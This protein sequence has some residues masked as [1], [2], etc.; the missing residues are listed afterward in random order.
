MKCPN[1]ANWGCFSGNFSDNGYDFGSSLFENAINKGC[2]M[3]D[4]GGPRELECS[5]FLNGSGSCKKQCDTDLCNDYGMD[6]RV[7]CQV[8]KESLD[9]TGRPR[10]GIMRLVFAFF[11]IKFI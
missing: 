8:C 6:T 9:H 3:F 1:Y 11:F 2:S 4:L 5:P 10:P 7:Q